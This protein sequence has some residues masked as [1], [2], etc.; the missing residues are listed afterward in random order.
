MTSRIPILA[1]RYKAT[2]FRG[3]DVST[4]RE[5]PGNGDVGGAARRQVTQPSVEQLGLGELRGRGGDLQDRTMRVATIG[6]TI[7]TRREAPGNGEVG[8]AERQQGTQ[9]PAEQRGKDMVPEEEWRR[10]SPRERKSFSKNH[11]KRK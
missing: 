1:I 9:S 2:V 4:R 10:M 5:V 3:G 7:S 6:G 8:G 11:K